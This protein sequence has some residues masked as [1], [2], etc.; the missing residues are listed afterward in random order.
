MKKVYSILNI[1]CDWQ[2]MSTISF[3]EPENTLIYTTK[4]DLAKG[5]MVTDHKTHRILRII[6]T[7]P[8]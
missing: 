8:T 4:R 7:G 1:V 5:I 6:Q 2:R 3:P